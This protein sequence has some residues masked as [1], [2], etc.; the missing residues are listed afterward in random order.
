MGEVKRAADIKVGVAGCKGAYTALV[1]DAEISAFL[2]KSALEAPAAQLDFDK[3]ALCFVRHGAW[4]L[5]KVHAM[6]HYILTVVEFSK[7]P[8]CSDR[9]PNLAASYFEWSFSEKRPDLPG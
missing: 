6:G 8:P 2:R 3:N 1:L 9:R 4:V 5:S 7:G